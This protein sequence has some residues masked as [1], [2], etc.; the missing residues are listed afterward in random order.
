MTKTT[1]VSLLQQL[2]SKQDSRA[3]SKF[4]QLYTPLIYQWVSDL[5]VA[6]PERN[7]VVQEVF[8][9]LL[10]KLSTFQYDASRSFRGW[11]RTVTINKCRDFLRK[12]NR[13]TEPTFLAHLDLAE[14]ND[15]DLLTQQ[16]YR[17]HLANSALLLM[18]KHFSKTSWQA[19]WEHVANGRP[20]S[21]VATELG[22]SVNA[23]Y[24]ARGRVLR[25]LKQELAGLWE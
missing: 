16:E 2:R 9:V 4:V 6:K 13:L 19:C 5:R 11:L 25:R 17:D 1:R 12:K 3:W 7:D 18:K 8:V 20:A 15:T 21:E 10:G 14:A 24:L 23:V 22:I